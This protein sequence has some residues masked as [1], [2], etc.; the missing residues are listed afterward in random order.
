MLRRLSRTVNLR[1]V[2]FLSTENPVT[3]ENRSELLK[4]F[5]KDKIKV[6]GPITVHEYMKLASGSA[7]GFYTKKADILG[8]SGDFTTAPEISQI[9]GEL[10]GIWIYNELYNTGE[11]GDWQL[12][13]LG[14]G[15]GTLMADVLRTLNVLKTE[16]LSINLVEISD[17]LIDQQEQLLCGRLTKSLQDSDVIRRNKTKDG[18]PVC[19]YRDLDS[20]PKEKFSVFLGNEF[21]DVLPVHL[22][23]KSD[24]DWKEVQVSINETSDLCLMLSKSENLHSKGL[25]PKY[26]REDPTRDKWELCPEAGKTV[27]EIAQRITAFGGFGLFIDYGHDGGRRTRSLRAYHNH[28]I[29]DVLS[30]PGL[31]DI[32]ADVDFGYLK[33]IL[34]GI[35]LP[36]G[37]ITQREFLAQMGLRLRTERLLQQCKD[38]TVQS[39]LRTAYKSLIDDSEDGM[40]IKFHMFSLFP[41]TLKP[42]LEMR[43][44]FPAGFF[45]NFDD[46]T[47]D[48]EELKEEI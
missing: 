20:V 33:K 28:K 47:E 22:F 21:L 35:C 15:T 10:I 9:F 6:S 32:T 7:A 11:R 30:K 14:P 18:V 34:E 2:G 27:T 29:V 25:I 43:G 8:A 3:I 23:E 40:G 46:F 48:L 36:F 13:E 12:V 45:P 39:H 44:G 38:E 16:R 37:P 31:I 1:A 5:I 17:H 26:I 41:T 19:W 4:R 24:G 42:I